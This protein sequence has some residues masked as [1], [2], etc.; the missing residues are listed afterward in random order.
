MW[1]FEDYGEASHIDVKHLAEFEAAVRAD[2][3]ARM[4]AS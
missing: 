4:E 3:R 1:C 2:E